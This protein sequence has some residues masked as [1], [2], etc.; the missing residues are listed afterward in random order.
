MP[1]NHEKPDAFQRQLDELS[2]Q[3]NVD[4]LDIEGSWTGIH[5]R[6]PAKKRTWV[7]YAAAAVV[8]LALFTYL[9]IDVNTDD[10]HLANE[11][12]INTISDISPELALLETDYQQ[13]V[14]SK[15]TEIES[16][17][18]DS[19]QIRF[20]YDEL[21]L[22]NQLEDEYEAELRAVG[23]NEKVVQTI[24]KC[25]ERRLELLEMLL[26]ESNKPRKE[27]QNEDHKPII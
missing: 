12:S 19:A 15:W 20:I 27:H 23:P 6:L 18:V 11:T 26:R 14:A 17:Q 21:E 5:H 2:E 8:I 3:L 13:Q 16:E 24:L 22:L 10:H 9:N 25:Y 7:W 4:E 1:D